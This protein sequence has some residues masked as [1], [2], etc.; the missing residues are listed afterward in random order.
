M[1]N[2]EA[3]KQRLDKT[4]DTGANDSSSAFSGQQV[5]DLYNQF[6]DLSKQKP[7]EP[8]W[9]PQFPSDSS[10][11]TGSNSVNP[12]KKESSVKGERWKSFQDAGQ[13]KSL[14]G[15]A[16]KD[17][18]FQDTMGDTRANDGTGPKIGDG[19]TRSPEQRRAD[20]AKR[21]A[22]IIG[23]REGMG[24]AYQRE[25]IER[26]YKEAFHNGGAEEVEKL[27]R[28]INEQLEKNGSDV[29]V[30]SK[31]EPRFKF[32][33][34]DGMSVSDEV[35]LDLKRGSEKV[36]EAR[37]EIKRDQDGQEDEPSWR[38]RRYQG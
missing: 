29:R 5:A 36:D 19:D 11:G 13:N 1:T 10:T 17:K 23:R 31:T 35:S 20:N 25:Q 27:T 4:P 15:G 30:S 18:G 34:N 28:E 7:Q 14:L 37:I 32:D 6:K 8:S 2:A 24:N 21:A 33:E 9:L 38:R 26:M 12:D 22:D 3:D 16:N